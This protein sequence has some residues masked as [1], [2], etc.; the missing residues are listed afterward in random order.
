MKI[1][2]FLVMLF[3]AAAFFGTDTNLARAEQGNVQMSVIVVER[4]MT[5]TINDFDLSDLNS[6]NNQQI[7]SKEKVKGVSTSDSNFWS[8]IFLV[9]E[10]P[11]NK[12]K[13]FFENVF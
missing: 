10:Y 11:L 13:C 3:L 7:V 2:F 9:I 8:D 6:D 1:N 12:V 5:D 4:K